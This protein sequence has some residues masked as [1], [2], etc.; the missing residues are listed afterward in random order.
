MSTHRK[1]MTGC[2]VAV[3][4]YGLVAC[5]SGGDDESPQAAAAPAASGGTVVSNGPP[6]EP[7]G[8]MSELEVAQ[9]A[10]ET[11]AVAAETASEDAD[12]ALAMAVAA[13]ANHATLQ[14]KSPDDWRARRHRRRGGRHGL[15]RQGEGSVC[16]G[17]GRGHQS[18]GDRGCH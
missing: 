11:A 2:C 12:E 4:T 8:M 10:A 1:L 13:A 5:S 6:D 17:P 7:V 3:L 15:R 18:G 16:R 14:T 9:T